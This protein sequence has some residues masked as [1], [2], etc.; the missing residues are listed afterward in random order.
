MTVA[1]EPSWD[2]AD[3]A[4]MTDEDF[5]DWCQTF[6]MSEVTE[7]L[8]EYKY[9]TLSEHIARFELSG[10]WKIVAG[11]KNDSSTSTD[12]HNLASPGNDLP[13]ETSPGMIDGVEITPGAEPDNDGGV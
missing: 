7:T 6:E 3:W 12:K 4:S 13:G 8:A 10:D 5:E 2:D 9:R 11:D 1:K